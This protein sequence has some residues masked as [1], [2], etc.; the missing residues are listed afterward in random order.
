MR[1]LLMYVH[2]YSGHH[3]AALALEKAF[4]AIQPRSE[5]LLVD[6]LRYT[7]PLLEGL[8]RRTY[9]EIIKKRPEVWEHLYDNPWVVQNTQKMRRHI[10]DSDSGKLSKLLS[11]FK[12]DA[13]VCTQ[14]FPCGMVAAYKTK[15]AAALPLYGVLTDYFPHS[16]WV[17]DHVTHYFVPCEEAKT[18]LYE[19]GIFERRI[20]VSGIPV[21]GLRDRHSRRARSGTPKVLV[22]GGS[23]GLGPIEKIVMALDRNNEAFDIIVT[24]GKN[25]KLFKTLQKYHKTARKN[26][27]VLSYESNVPELMA[28]ASILVTK[29]GGLTITQAMNAGLPI[30]FID[31]IPGQEA[32]NASFL[33]KHKAALEAKSVSEV[34][35]FTAQLLRFPAKMEAMKKSMTRLARPDASIRIARSILS[36]EFI[37]R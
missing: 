27:Q 32:Q 37:G 10:H 15:H 13:V 17:L 35:L 7:H 24:T 16:Y 29:P 26:I 8:I 14:A 19:N 9:L 34:A 28:Q 6:A 22:M 30:V 23:Q 12:P 36:R 11:E 20:S 2:E 21:E 25:Q 3:H 4:R 18:R 5:C 1:I 33:L 31:P